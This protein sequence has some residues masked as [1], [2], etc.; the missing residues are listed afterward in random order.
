MECTGGD[1]GPERGIVSESCKKSYMHLGDLEAVAQAMAGIA[2]S[3]FGHRIWAIGLL[4]AKERVFQ[5]EE[6]GNNSPFESFT[7]SCCV[8]PAKRSA[9][10]EFNNIR[11]G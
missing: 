1:A 8:L 2:L 11:C 9:A 4:S 10:N 5:R 3:V 7:R 6:A